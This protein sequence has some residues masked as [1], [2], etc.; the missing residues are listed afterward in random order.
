[1][2]AW[3]IRRV[4]DNAS[5]LTWLVGIGVFVIGSLSIA[6]GVRHAFEAGILLFFSTVIHEG[7]HACTSYAFGCPIKA[8]RCSAIGP[9]IVRARSESANVELAIASAGPLANLVLSVG[10]IYSGSPILI[11][12]GLANL[13]MAVINLLPLRN[14]DGSRVFASLRAMTQSSRVAS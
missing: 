8:V 4:R 14:S 10:L 13:I 2:A 9:H 1:M 5:L 6:F 11:W 12:T 7:A 3:A